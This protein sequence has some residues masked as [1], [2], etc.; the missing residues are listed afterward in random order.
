MSL[1]QLVT[2]LLTGIFKILTAGHG[3]ENGREFQGTCPPPHCPRSG[4][5]EEW[6]LNRRDSVSGNTVMVQGPLI[7][8]SSAQCVHTGARLLCINPL[9]GC[10]F[11][12]VCLRSGSLFPIDLCPQM[13][14]LPTCLRPCLFLTGVL[15]MQKTFLGRC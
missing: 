6:T 2:T 15:H 4:R 10:H 11:C 8:N 7:L 1:A 14:R 9:S 13:L 5:E 12:T 3:A